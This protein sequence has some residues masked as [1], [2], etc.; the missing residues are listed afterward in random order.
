MMNIR[1]Q[2]GQR[3]SVLRK[4]KKWSMRELAEHTES[5]KQ[6]RINNYER[7]IRLPG[8]EE[9]KQLG[10]ALGVSPAYILCLADDAYD[11]EQNKLKQLPLFDLVSAVNAEKLIAAMNSD[12]DRF[13]NNTFI[14]VPETM[15]T[16]LSEKCFAVLIEDT[17][18]EPLLS[19]QDLLFIDMEKQPEPGQIVAAKIANENSIIIRKYR[20]RS[21][22]SK[23]QEHAFELL[24]TNPDWAPITI[25]NNKQG[26]ILG[27]VIGF[28]RLLV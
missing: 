3:I 8:A 22:D 26:E 2:I 15:A 13:S 24:P 14:P 16:H 28:N 17:S 11:E 18:L 23:T 20:Q 25:E 19:P 7:G 4:A 9:A 6:S 1:E 12:L 21:V 10:K 27:T 5:L